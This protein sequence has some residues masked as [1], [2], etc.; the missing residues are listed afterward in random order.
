MP[1]I[2][3]VV[4]L[5][6]LSAVAFAQSG[7]STISG[8]V[9]DPTSAVVPGAMIKIVNLDSGVQLE[10]V[11]NEAG[12]YRVGALLP[13]RYQV[14]VDA[15]GFDR[16]TRGPITLQV[17]QTVAIDVTV[18]IGK[19]TEA[20]IVT[21]AAPLTESQ[22][23]N[24]AQTVN[25]Q[26]LA[27]LPLPNRAASSL[28]SLAPGVIMVDTGTG[29]AE[30]YPVFTVA[31]GRTRNQTF[32]L[33][34]GNV[35]NAVGLTRNQQLTSLPV[36]AMQEFQVVANNY[37]AEHG[38]STGGIVVMSTRAGT[39]EYH[40]SLF[41]SLQ[42]D[43][44]N[45]RN[46]FA[47]SKQPIRLNQFGGSL[48][49]PIRK[50]KTFF[51]VTWERTRQLTSD[52]LASTVPTLLNRAGDFSDLRTS[53]GAP[54]L[55]Y[56]PATTSGINRQ[57]FPGNKIPLERLDPVAL[58]ALRFFPLPNSPGT[59]TNSNN[60]VGSSANRLNRDI[61]VGRFDHR[62]TPSD[63]L[64]V[65]YYIND[66]DTYNNGTY[67]IP[68]ADPLGDITDVRVQSI[69]GAYT[70]IFNPAVSNDIRFTYLRRK[71]ND[72][73]PGAGENL[74]GQIGLTGVTD[75]AFPAFTIPGYATLGNPAAVARF[76]TPILD[77]QILNALSW[78]KGKHAWKF[79]V[80]FRAGANDE[81]R[82][83]GSAGNFTFSPLITRLPGV[84][85]TGNALASFLLGEVNAA[86]VQVSDKIQTR[87]SYLAFYAQDDWRIT[88]RLTINA[89]LRWEAEFPRREINNKMNSFDA[90]AI[91]PVSS[92]PG[93]VTFAGVNGTPERAFATDRNNFGPRLGFAYRIPGN[94]ETVIR[95]GGGI[96]Y[97]QTVS[98]TIGDTASLGFSDAASYV[99][100]QA[101]FQSALRLRDGFPAFSRQPLTPAFGAVPLDQRPNTAISFFNPKQVAPISYQYNLGIQREV[102]RN[103]LFEVGYMANVSH[104]LTANDFSLNQVP[105]Q[106]MGPGDAQL[107]RPFPQFSNVTWINPSIGNSTYHAGFV[108]AEKRFGSGFS[109]LAHYTLSKF[110]DDVESAD[111][112]GITG[113]YMDAYNRQLDKGRSGSDVPHRLMLTVLYEIPS[114]RG[115][116]F[117]SVALGGWKVGVLQT[118]QSGAPFTVITTANTTNAFPAG[119]LRPNLSRDPSLPSGERT[120]T[121]W[122]DTTAFGAPAPF[123]FG[124]SPRSGLRGA[125][126]VTTD[127]TLEKSFFITERWKFDLRAEFYNLLNHA[128]FNI[129][130]FAFGAPDFGVVSSARAGRTVQLAFRLSF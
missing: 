35:S 81:I 54:V 125:S 99:V 77:R 1:R 124:N 3:A 21:E 59:I 85:G 30:N 115:N 19:Q 47:P 5:L 4:M 64:T 122:F 51:F 23:S 32:V 10:T 111:E 17:S 34:G 29:T 31:G 12:L 26:M 100:A 93:V 61:V 96:F 83:R 126:L 8:T 46:F 36:D 106:L 62:V 105:P 48:G 57:P 50:D 103:L 95:G 27:G 2:S 94:R 78:Y 121:R 113:N 44:L 58:E 13:G 11:T 73:R 91:N 102:A 88:D 16:I 79:G 20:V 24:V 116:R 6:G 117:A 41:E 42:N 53:Y 86:S 14:E 37:S 55:I 98:N 120:I 109:F 70:H 25:R 92:T 110:L 65:R 66:S 101:E 15:S 9:K 49:G 72:S 22:S 67:G 39:G 33:D 127:L 68:E 63:L 82:D 108:R 52:T 84:A 118:A 28:A 112:Y 75:A 74:A 130:G 123:T 7:N 40:G 45:A 76:Q 119:P 104:H 60:Y 89:G 43:V 56:D 97:G 90:T 69:L 107:L 114:F 80:E 18:E 129:P 71:F 87:A 38:H 128:N